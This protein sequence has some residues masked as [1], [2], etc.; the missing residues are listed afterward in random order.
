M[1]GAT[2]QQQSHC[3]AWLMA[4]SLLQNQMLR[5]HS[6][7]W[8][9]SHI[10]RPWATSHV[11]LSHRPSS[12]QSHSRTP[13]SSHEPKH[14]C[15]NVLRPSVPHASLE[16]LTCYAVFSGDPPAALRGFSTPTSS[17]CPPPSHPAA[18][19]EEAGCCPNQA[20]LTCLQARALRAGPCLADA[21]LWKVH[22]G[23]S[24]AGAC[25]GAVSTPPLQ[26]P[27]P[28]GSQ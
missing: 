13:H 28:P 23:W 11:L 20:L 24:D 17:T 2:A 4:K 5:G 27:G 15:D 1:F 10:L 22:P 21:L 9:T 3:S 26:A 14:L 12:K 16:A 7:P 25:P 8:A 18:H 6:K 19:H